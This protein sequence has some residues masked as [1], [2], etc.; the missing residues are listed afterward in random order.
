M[1]IFIASRRILISGDYHE[2]M[3]ILRVFVA[4]HKNN[5][6][7]WGDFSRAKACTSR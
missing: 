5:A 2:A 7:L 6:N 3:R 4:A 1:I